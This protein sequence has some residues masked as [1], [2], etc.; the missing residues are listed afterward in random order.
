MTPTFLLYFLR[1]ITHTWDAD[2][3]RHGSAALRGFGS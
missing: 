1:H 2:R 3:F